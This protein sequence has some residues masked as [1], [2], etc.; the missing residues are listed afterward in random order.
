M[1][2]AQGHDGSVNPRVRGRYHASTIP[3]SSVG[4]EPPRTGEIRMEG[5]NAPHSNR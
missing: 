2:D 1:V 5:I 3:L 4:G